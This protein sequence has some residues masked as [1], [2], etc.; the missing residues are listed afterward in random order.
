M[1]MKKSENSIVLYK[2]FVGYAYNPDPEYLRERERMA[3]EL[4]RWV[5]EY[6]EGLFVVLCD[7]KVKLEM[8]FVTRTYVVPKKCISDMSVLND[9]IKHKV[10]LQG[11]ERM[12]REYYWREKHYWNDNV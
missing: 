8:D 12:R 7:N 4:L 11:E 1:I 2:S 3:A 6:P 9:W 5:K 10:V